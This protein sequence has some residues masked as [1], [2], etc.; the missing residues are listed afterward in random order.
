MISNP[1]QANPL[2][3]GRNDEHIDKKVELVSRG[4]QSELA[5]VNWSAGRIKLTFICSL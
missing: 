3:T 5:N 4:F 2:Q 1:V